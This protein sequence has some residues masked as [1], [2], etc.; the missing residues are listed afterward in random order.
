MTRRASRA[1]LQQL[2]R[3]SHLKLEG[4]TDAWL[5]NDS[6][7]VVAILD[8]GCNSWMTWPGVSGKSRRTW[9][10][11]QQQV[12]KFSKNVK[13]QRFLDSHICRD[14][15]SRKNLAGAARYAANIL[16]HQISGYPFFETQRS[17]W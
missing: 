5:G 4:S 14:V 17:I 8:L 12:E 16:G 11:V 7:M 1:E 2:R 6:D 3:A 9:R 10:C 15:M 13:A